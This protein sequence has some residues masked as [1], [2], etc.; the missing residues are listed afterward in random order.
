MLAH[1]ILQHGDVDRRIELGNPDPVAKPP[2]GFRRVSA[3]AQAA[4]RRHPGV[5][6]AVDE[7]L[8][9][10]FQQLALAHHRIRQIQPREFDLLRCENTQ[11]ANEPVV[12]RAVVLEF[13]GANRV[14]DLFDRI[15][16]PVREIVHRVD[17]PLVAGAMMRGVQDPIQDR[18]A[19]VQVRMRHVDLGA[20]GPRAV[21]EFA[22]PH[23]LKQVQILRHATIA[24]R[25]VAAG[26]RQRSAVLTHLV[27]GQLANV[28]LAVPNQLD[29]PLVQLLEIVGGEKQAIRPIEAEPADVLHD[30]IDVFQLFFAGIRIV[31]TQVA[32]ALVL[33]R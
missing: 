15:G 31:E 16:L 7:P 3:A 2:D 25:A 9:D 1:A 10:Q 28:R 6:P 33:G 21:R 26:L 4:D 12:Q 5:V 13:Q 22:G 11:L 32:Q 18:I 8:F 20:Q 14:R 23:P 27:R 17:A 30:R 19:E 29:A 24:A